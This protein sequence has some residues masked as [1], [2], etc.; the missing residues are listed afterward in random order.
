MRK[1]LSF[2]VMAMLGIA[3]PQHS[4]ALSDGTPSTGSLTVV[5][6]SALASASASGS[7]TVVTTTALT[8]AR[9]SIG[10]YVFVAGREFAVGAS[11]AATATNLKNAINAS[12]QNLVVASYSPGNTVITLTAV[13]IGTLYNGVTLRASDAGVLSVSGAN[14]TG[15]QD[16]AI[17]TINGIPLVQGRDWFKQDVA[18]NTAVN[19]AASINLSPDLRQLVRAAWPGGSSGVVFL[20]S[21]TTPLAYTLASSAGSALTVSAATMTGGSSGNITL[22]PCN[23]GPVNALPT[24]NY[25]PGC[26]AFLISD[27]TKLYLSTEPVTSAQSWLGK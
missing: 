5:T 25:P 10:P 8:G 20:R 7:A 26:T 4:Q 9:V 11:T 27:P 12:G 17:V 19:L 24:S 1:M 16:N 21:A 23:L 2:V 6:P 14:L 15:G 22:A 13:D 18:S 3:A